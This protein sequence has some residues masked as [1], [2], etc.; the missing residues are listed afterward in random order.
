MEEV[1]EAECMIHELK[2]K[3]LNEFNLLFHKEIT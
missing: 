2:I 1:K 3:I